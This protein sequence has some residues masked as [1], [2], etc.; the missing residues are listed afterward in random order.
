MLLPLVVLIQYFLPL[1]PLAA[2]VA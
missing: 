2:V 1:H